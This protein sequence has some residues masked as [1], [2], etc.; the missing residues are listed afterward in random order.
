MEFAA[1]TGYGKPLPT[2]KSTIR[3]NTMQY[4]DRQRCNAFDGE[5]VEA[6][7]QFTVTQREW[8]VESKMRC[9]HVTT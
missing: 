4:G 1:L 3:R 9:C 2:L 6:V 8:K 5:N 7:E